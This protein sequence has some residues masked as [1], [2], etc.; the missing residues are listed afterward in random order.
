VLLFVSNNV[1]NSALVSTSV[2]HAPG[3]QE[4]KLRLGPELSVAKLLGQRAQ[5]TGRKGLGRV[6]WS[7]ILTEHFRP[8]PLGMS[9]VRS[10]FVRPKAQ[11]INSRYT[12]FQ[13]NGTIDMSPMKPHRTFSESQCWKLLSRSHDYRWATSG[14]SVLYYFHADWTACRIP[15][16][17]HGIGASLGWWS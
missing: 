16:L 5:F 15:L 3:S 2:L 13:T 12:L 1:H 6:G 17:A 9:S 10:R 14:N 4:K 8:V 7:N 11:K